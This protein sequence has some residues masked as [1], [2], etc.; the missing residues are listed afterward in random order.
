MIVIVMLDAIDTPFRAR[1]LPKFKEERRKRSSRLAK[2]GM[3]RKCMFLSATFTRFGIS[4]RW[5]PKFTKAQ[6]GLLHYHVSINM[7]SSLIISARTVETQ[8]FPACLN[9]N[10]KYRYYYEYLAQSCTTCYSTVVIKLLARALVAAVR[11]EP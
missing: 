10:Y 9:I 8:P 11:S 7:L 1:V 4:I 2:S 5:Y 6:R 3:K